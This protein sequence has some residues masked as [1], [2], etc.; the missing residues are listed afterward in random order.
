MAKNPEKYHRRKARTSYVTTVISITLV[1]FMLGILG[2]LILHARKLSDY[3]RE[4]IGFSIMIKTGVDEQEI[5]NF[6]RQLNSQ[7]YVKSTRYVTRE[8]AALVLKKELGEDFIGFLGYN[9]LLPLIELRLKADYTDVSNFATIEKNLLA[10]P[11]VKEVFYQK[12]LVELVN[13]NIRTISFVILGISAV[14]LI[15]SI[16]LINNTIQLSVYS[17]RFS[18]RTMQLVGAT[19]RFIRKPFVRRGILSGFLSAV[20]AISMLAGIMALGMEELPGLADL[21]DPILYGI[22]GILIFITGIMIS[23]ISTSLA[24][25]KYLKMKVDD[26]YQ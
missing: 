7:P 26:L 13:K 11:R 16:A 20:F 6:Q 9:P 19:R 17:H 23:W 2:L 12:S 22:L 21:F 18:I 25:R 1:L 10:D 3:A 15:I 8:E 14:L 4:N 24:V 5:R